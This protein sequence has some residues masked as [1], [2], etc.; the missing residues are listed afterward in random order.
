[1]TVILEIPNRSIAQCRKIWNRKA[2]LQE[3]EPVLDGHQAADLFR[4]T[5]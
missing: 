1:M 4:F 2:A 3:N 5:R